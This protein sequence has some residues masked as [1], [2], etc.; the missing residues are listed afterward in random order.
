MTS[1]SRPLTWGLRLRLAR[2]LSTPAHRRQRR[3]ERGATTIEMVLL[4]IAL[5]TLLFLGLEAGLYY[6]ARSVAIAA[7]QEGAREAGSQHGSQAS[8]IAAAQQFLNQAG[9]PGVIV[10]TNV[11][12]SRTATTA[13]VTVTGDSMSVI[14]GIH[15][16]ITQSATVPV[17]RLTQ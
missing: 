2:W 3:D 4:M 17:E 7:A 11:V 15:V 1:L 5:F 12:G 13:T 6:H 10:N 8:G 14:P 9:G 16:A